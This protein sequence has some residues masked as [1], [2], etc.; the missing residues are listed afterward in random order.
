MYL[1]LRQEFP[2]PHRNRTQGEL[3]NWCWWDDEPCRTVSIETDGTEIV[4]DPTEAGWGEFPSRSF[5][6][7]VLSL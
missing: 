7:S 6:T 5:L 1:D 2:L 3:T 4:G